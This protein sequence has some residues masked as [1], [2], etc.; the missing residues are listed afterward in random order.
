MQKRKFLSS[1]PFSDGFSKN[2]FY[3]NQVSH[4][5]FLCVE[6]HDR[7]FSSLGRE[8]SQR[9]HKSGLIRVSLATLN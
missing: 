5:T 4:G 3:R 8:K 1:E 7:Q 9:N 2:L 6:F